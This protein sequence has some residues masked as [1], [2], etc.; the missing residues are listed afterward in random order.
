MAETPR[1]MV[2]IY[3]RKRDTVTLECVLDRDKETKKVLRRDRVVLGS[4][5]DE[6][7]TDPKVPK[8]EITMSAARWARFM[9]NEIIAAMVNET[10]MI[11]VTRG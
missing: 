5:D 9:D 6:L 3:N 7:A 10:R 4:H 8:P 2:R 11:Q 1:D